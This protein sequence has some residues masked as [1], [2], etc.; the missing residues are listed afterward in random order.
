MRTFL[1][2]VALF[3]GKAAYFARES[4]TQ[5]QS[6]TSTA[7]CAAAPSRNGRPGI[8]DCSVRIRFCQSGLKDST[9]SNHHPSVL[10]IHKRGASFGSHELYNGPDKTGPGEVPNIAGTTPFPLGPLGDAAQKTDA[11]KMFRQLRALRLLWNPSLIPAL[12]SCG[13]S[14][15]SAGP[16]CLC[17]EVRRVN[18]VRLARTEVESGRHAIIAP[19][20][21]LSCYRLNVGRR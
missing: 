5:L 3:R 14:V 6:N 21:T 19:L 20:R 11:W 7:L 10:K 12:A 15:L 13:M 18:G 16:T 9:P 2:K 17:T 8:R 4:L 1:C